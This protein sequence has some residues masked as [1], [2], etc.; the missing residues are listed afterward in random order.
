MFTELGRVIDELRKDKGLNREVVIKALEAALLKVAKNK[1]G[2]N[3]A[4]EACFNEELGE[5]ELFRF[6][7]VVEQVMNRGKEITVEEAHT[8]DPEAE[9]GDS[10]G[11]KMDTSQFGRIAAQ[12]AKQVIMQSLREAERENI[13]LEFKDKKGDLVTG[14]VQRFDKGDIVVTL[15][16]SEALLPIQEQI[17]RESFSLRER[18]KAY[19]IDVKKSTKGPQILLSRTH[20]GFLSK[21]FEL[22]VPEI[23]E[24]I[25][26]IRSVAREP[27]SRAKFAVESTDPRVDPVGA[28]VGNRGNRV[29]NV[30]HELRGEK[31]DIIP[32]TPDHAKFACS[33][34]APAEVSEIIVDEQDHSMEVIVE[35]DQLSLAIGKKGQ[36]VRLAAKLTNW[37]ID[38]KSR[39]KAEGALSE[40]YDKLMAIPGI[41]KTT[42]EILLKENYLSAED[43]IAARLEDLIAIPG[44]GEKKAKKIKESAQQALQ[45]PEQSEPQ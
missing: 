6:R 34:L 16:K 18:V 11:E 3:M 7:T 36:N 37:R 1:Y 17:P 9:L 41:G 4:I 42:A 14:I 12:T 25:V 13:F 10:L 43:I 20:P 22:E 40:G 44:I 30:V 33:A 28:C 27:G 19:I 32:W 35:D 2:Q 38:I 24:G 15:G 31:I 39:S 26:K 45:K 5:V 21:L 8:I 23:S 29:Q